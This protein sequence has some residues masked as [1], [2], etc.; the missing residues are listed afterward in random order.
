VPLG[1]QESL[2][3]G[4]NV[5]TKGNEMRSDLLHV[6]TVVSN[7]VRWQSRMKLYK[8]FE[9][10]ML[11]SGVKLTTV[12]VSFGDRPTELDSPYVNHVKIRANGHALVWHKESALNL[13]IARLPS[14]AKYIATI[15]A[16]VEFRR[17][18]WAAESVHALQHYHVIQPSV[19]CYDLGPNGEHLD[20]HKSFCSLVHQKKPIVQGPNTY[21][22]LYRFGH[23]GYAWCYT[24]QALEW[25]GGVVDTA[26][27]GAADHHMAMALIGRVQDS[28]PNSIGQPYKE[29]LLRWQDRANRH[30]A[31][32]ITCIGGTIEHGFHG[33]KA[34]RG[35]VDRWSILIKN[36]FDPAI[37]LKH[38]TYGLVEL[39]GNKPHLQHDID[40]YFRGRREDSNTPD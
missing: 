10:H 32:N 6:V 31:R 38:N 39:A 30:I 7:P 23:P 13:G 35:Y 3:S 37:D 17:K 15:D 29:P 1:Y 25:L 12:E 26:A 36:A 40:L 33:P 21:K 9:E 4:F 22:A 2:L 11:D 18:D 8:R 19:D 20:H 27:L 28:I 5:R 34:S 16:D 24:R 14:E